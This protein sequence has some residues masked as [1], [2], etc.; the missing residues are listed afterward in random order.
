MAFVVI[1]PLPL[2]LTA[3]MLPDTAEGAQR[4]WPV[5]SQ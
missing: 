1:H 3:A 5:F 2:V 4:L